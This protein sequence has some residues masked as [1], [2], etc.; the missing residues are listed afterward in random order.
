MIIFDSYWGFYAIRKIQ[1][2]NKLLKV[3]RG[4]VWYVSFIH[5]CKRLIYKLP[6]QVETKTM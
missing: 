6:V 2:T 3:E 1:D 4:E 5:L